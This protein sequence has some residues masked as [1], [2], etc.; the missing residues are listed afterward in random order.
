[1]RNYGNVKTKHI[2][3]YISALLWRPEVRIFIYLQIL[4]FPI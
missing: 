1:M 4:F 3:Y 2:I